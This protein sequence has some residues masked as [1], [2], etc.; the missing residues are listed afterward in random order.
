MSGYYLQL[1]GERFL[2]LL[3]MTAIIV[4]VSEIYLAFFSV[5]AIK[6]YGK[7]Q[8]KINYYYSIKKRIFFIFVFNSIFLFSNFIPSGS[9]DIFYLK[10]GIAKIAIILL[11]LMLIIFI[12]THR[13]VALVKGSKVS[14]L[15]VIAFIA[16]NIIYIYLVILIYDPMVNFKFYESGGL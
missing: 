5:I 13:Y 12:A 3:T 2:S 16:I 9:S 4:F 6:F 10:T 8:S 15:F 1:F 14:T 7:N 11:V